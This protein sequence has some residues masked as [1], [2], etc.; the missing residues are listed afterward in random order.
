MV[1]AFIL[2]VGIFFSKISR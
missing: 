1:G 2:G